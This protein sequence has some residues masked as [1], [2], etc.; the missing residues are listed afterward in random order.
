MALPVAFFGLF[1]AY[2]VLAIVGRGL[3]SDG[4]WH[5]GRFGEV[6]A[7]PDVLHVLWFTVWQ[8]AASTGCTLALALPGAYV[9]A[10]F[11]FPGKQLL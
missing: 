1:F 5:L 4:Q 10:R 7:E 6:L 8:A 3:S 2:P 11:D 9:F